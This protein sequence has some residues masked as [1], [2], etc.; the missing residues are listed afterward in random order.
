M[1][2]KTYR[3]KHSRKQSGGG[4]GCGGTAVLGFPQN[5]GQMNSIIG[6]P[7]NSRNSMNSTMNSVPVNRPM[8]S[9]MNSVPVNRPMNSTMNSMR[10]NSGMNS[11]PVNSGMQFNNSKLPNS[12]PVNDNPFISLSGGFL[13]MFNQPSQQTGATPQNVVNQPSMMNQPRDVNNRM[14][15]L[16][17]RLKKLETGGGFFGGRRSARRKSRGT[18]KHKSRKH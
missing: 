12:Q 5:G 8:N 3:K 6:S 16:E 7:N 2:R 15:E 9:T 13:D 1:V 18:R 17:N 4:C 14:D 11:M 10:V